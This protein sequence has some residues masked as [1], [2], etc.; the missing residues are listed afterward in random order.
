M[1]RKVLPYDFVV[2]LLVLR[3]TVLERVP[4]NRLLLVPGRR[5]IHLRKIPQTIVTSWT[6]KEQASWIE[7]TAGTRGIERKEACVEMAVAVSFVPFCNQ[8]NI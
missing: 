1:L 4:Q 6:T 7:L 3:G 2:Y 8:K 5:H